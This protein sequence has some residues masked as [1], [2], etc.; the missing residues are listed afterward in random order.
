MTDAGP[1][2]LRIGR[3]LRAHGVK[4]AVLVELLTDFV[5]RFQPGSAVD[6][7]GRRLMVA[8]CQER[9]SEVLV[10]FDGI[11]DRDAATA[12]AGA[13]CT[14]PL[15]AARKLPADRYYH[16]QLVGL[17]VF[18]TRSQRELGR[19]VEVLPYAANDVLRV[20]DGDR[21]TLIPLVKAV[22]QAVDPGSGRITVA[23]PGET[24]V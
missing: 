20:V 22:V 24:E 11:G 16:F 2:E 15:S 3:V 13:Y 5:D 12:I 21:E 9:N 17:T 10:T 14:L 6:V 19:V 23:L 18:D 4:G 7:D 8:T 1:S